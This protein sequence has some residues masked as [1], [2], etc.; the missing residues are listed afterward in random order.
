[1]SQ[2]IQPDNRNDQL[3]YDGLRDLASITS[4]NAEIDANPLFQLAESVI[5]EHIPDAVLR[6]Q[7]EQGKGRTFQRRSTVISILQFLA[8]ANFLRGGGSIGAETITEGTGE[9]KSETERVAYLT[10][11]R[12]F[13]VGSSSSRQSAGD[14]TDADR[15]TWLEDQAARLLKTF[16]VD[17]SAVTT[18]SPFVVQT[19][20][21]LKDYG[22]DY[23]EGVYGLLGG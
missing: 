11:V 23:D 9:L 17:L 13:D 3:A 21:R 1:M 15:A 22:D 4:S 14:V 12:Q 8:A 2:V 16:G 20:S 5:V 19:S 18:D 6:T 7:P 10:T